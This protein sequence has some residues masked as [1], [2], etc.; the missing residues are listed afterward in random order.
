MKGDNLFIWVLVALL[1]AG[2]AATLLCTPRGST[3]GYGH[4][5]TAVG[6]LG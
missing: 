2:I 3:H 6:S 5:L 1:L 4:R